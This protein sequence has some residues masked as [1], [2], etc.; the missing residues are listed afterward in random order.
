MNIKAG[1]IQ[2][3]QSKYDSWNNAESSA[4]LNTLIS[5]QLISETVLELPAQALKDIETEIAAYYQLRSWGAD[6]MKDRYEAHGLPV[7]NNQGA[8]TSYDFHWTTDSELKLIEINTNAAFLAL[9][10]ELYAFLKTEISFSN[11][12]IVGMFSNEAKLCGRDLKTMTIIDEEPKHQRL[13]VEFLLYQ[14]M[15]EQK[16]IK[17]EIK[18]IA[19]INASEKSDLIY[20]RYT[21]FY[22]NNQVKSQVIRDLYKD[23]KINLSPNPYE[24]FL[25]A[26]KQRMIEWQHQSDLPVPKSLLKTFDLGVADRAVIWTERKKYFFKPKNSYGSK[27]AYKGAA[28]SRKTFDDFYGPSMLAQEYAQPAETEVHVGSETLKMKY[29]LRCYAYQGKLQIVIARLYQGQ[30]T[31]LKT[32]GG[33]FTIV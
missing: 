11:N 4:L 28:V 16:G 32:T 14:K 24:Y 8:C 25:L 33:G 3:L 19:E 2:Y 7:P 31:N 15:M 1:F 9:G 13:Y 21:D 22:L 17:T 6:K 10:T 18:D 29:D 30:T 5:D 23:G 20:N 26:D 12:D 27:Q